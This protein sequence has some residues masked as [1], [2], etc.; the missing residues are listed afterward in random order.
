MEEV[1]VRRR[2]GRTRLEI[3]WLGFGAMR[4]PE[5]EDGK[6]DPEESVRII[7]RAFESGVN[8]IDTA[9]GYCHGESEA[10]VGLALKGWRDRVYVSTKNH[11]MGPDEKAWWRNLENSLARL[12][13]DY[14]DVYNIHGINWKAWE[15]RVKGPN[16]VL[17]WMKK[18]H[19]QGLFRHLCC[20]FHDTAEA[21]EK[22]VATDEFS[23][24]TLQYNLLDRSLEPV[25][26]KMA[27]KDIGLV[28]MGPVGG[29]RLGGESENLRRLIAGARSVPEVALRFVWANPYVTCAISG[30]SN[31]EQ[32]VENCAAAMRPE[33]LTADEREQVLA[34]LERYKGLADLYCTGCNYCMPCPYGVDIPGTFSAV[35]AERVYGLGA[36]ARNQYDGLAGKPTYCTTCG[37]CESKCPQHIPIRAQ[38]QEAAKRFDP[39]FGQM[40]VTFVPVGR[41]EDGIRFRVELHNLSDHP[42]KAAVRI[43]SDNNVVFAPDRFDADVKDAFAVSQDELTVRKADSEARLLHIHADIADAAGRRTVSQTFRLGACYRVDSMDAL[44]ARPAD[45]APLSIDCEHQVYDGEELLGNPHGLRAWPGYSADALHLLGHVKH[46][47]SDGKFHLLVLLDFRDR[48]RALAPG[49][50][51]GMYLL[52]LTW[53]S[54]GPV[55][56]HVVRGEFDSTQMR[57]DAA[58]LAEGSEVRLSLPWK[59]VGDYGPKT[60]QAFGLDLVLVVMDMEERQVFRAGWSGN[61]RSQHDGAGLGAVFFSG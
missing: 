4:L 59:A 9:V 26:P 41:G 27:E 46:G 56:K 34:T 12:D 39:S 33:P 47:A 58:P 51:K 35:N 60:G 61:P 43:S 10:I 49:F 1:M 25:F 37:A 28:V 57:F 29:G 36:H 2:L 13:V 8:Y 40:A 22:I 50:Q 52:R 55:E 48:R 7:H 54:A 44:C 53:T 38:L 23:S 6:P 20:S 45:T 32:V 18:A 21:L 5:R 24:V 42:N 19:N 3:S 17:A 16:Q 31:M 15:E 30:M 14:I 11:Y